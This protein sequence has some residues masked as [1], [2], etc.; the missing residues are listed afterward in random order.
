MTTIKDR[1]TVLQ[2][3]KAAVSEWEDATRIQQREAARKAEAAVAAERDAGRRIRTEASAEAWK[4][5]AEDAKRLLTEALSEHVLTLTHHEQ[6][7]RYGREGETET[8]TDYFDAFCSCGY[9]GTNKDGRFIAFSGWDRIHKG[10]VITTVEEKHRAH[11]VA[12]VAESLG[13]TE[14]DEKHSFTS[15]FGYLMGDY[16]AAEAATE[17]TVEA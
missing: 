8:N 5:I 3:T 7:K 4:A 16:L 10:Q 11:V 6:G 1:I 17:A 13:L 14:W 2:A 15:S 9:D 12:F